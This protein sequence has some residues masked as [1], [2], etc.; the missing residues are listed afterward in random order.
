LPAGLPIG[1]VAAQGERYRVVLFADQSLA[2]DVEVLDFKQPAEQP[3]APSPGD[4]PVTAAGL[5]PA[6]PPPQQVSPGP[7]APP[8]LKPAPVVTPTPTKPAQ[9]GAPA[10]SDE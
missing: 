1:T 10:V 9:L 2:E 6:A 8:V 7:V 5:P 3:P 4:L